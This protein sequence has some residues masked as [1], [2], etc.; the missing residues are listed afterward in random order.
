M[1]SY[2]R[3]YIGAHSCYISLT[4]RLESQT[5]HEYIIAYPNTA[6]ICFPIFSL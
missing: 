2:F 6:E 1:H 4:D 3:T 5:V